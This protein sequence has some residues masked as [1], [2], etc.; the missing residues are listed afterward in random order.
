LEDNAVRF[1]D[2]GAARPVDIPVAQISGSIGNVGTDLSAESPLDLRAR[3]GSAGMLTVRGAAVAEPLS[4][5]LSVSLERFGL[6]LVDPY[7]A[8]VLTLGLDEGT[9]GTRGELELAGDRVRYRGSI[10]VDDL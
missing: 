9:A 5:R 2:L 8:E 6:P 3:I 1:R 7:V 10:Q 4:A